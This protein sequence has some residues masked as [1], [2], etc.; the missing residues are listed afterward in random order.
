MKYEDH[1]LLF[2]QQHAS[3][4]LPALWSEFQGLSLS[5]RSCNPRNDQLRIFGTQ[6]TAKRGSQGAQPYKV[7][8]QI[9]K[10]NAHKTESY[11]LLQKT[12]EE[13]RKRRPFVCHICHKN[14][15]EKQT[16]KGHYLR[17]H[18]INVR[19]AIKTEPKG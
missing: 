10:N 3:F 9:A 19:N 4:L 12:L 6:R 17:V 2:L 18:H 14:F 8:L 15:R 1:K 11:E 5:L 16:Q 13:N 7:T